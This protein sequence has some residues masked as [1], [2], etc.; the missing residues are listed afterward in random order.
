MFQRLVMG[1]SEQPA[2]E[3]AIGPAQTEM[4]EQG[5]EDLLD[6]ILGRR[7]REAERANVTA[8]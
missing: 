8:Q 3:I 4:P 5:E 6:Q 7:R 2:L 1:D